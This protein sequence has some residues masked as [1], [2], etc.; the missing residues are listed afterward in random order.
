MRER[1]S[2]F[3]VGTSGCSY[4]TSGEGTWK[5]VFYP[6]GKVDELEYYAEGFN[7]VEVNSTF[8]GS[9]APGYV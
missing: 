7:A 9:L 8:Y 1:E 2:V 3:R 4:P 6:S 5:G